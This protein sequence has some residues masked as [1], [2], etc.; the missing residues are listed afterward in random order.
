MIEVQWGTIFVECWQ[1]WSWRVEICRWVVSGG[2]QCFMLKVK[3]L[4]ID[5]KAG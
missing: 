4:K 5:G 3:G 2:N 1:I